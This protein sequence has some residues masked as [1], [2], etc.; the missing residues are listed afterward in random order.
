MWVGSLVLI[1]NLPKAEA[2]FNKK[3]SLK[4]S[5]ISARF[6]ISLGLIRQSRYQEARRLIA[7]NIR[8]LNPDL[9]PEDQF[10]IYQS[11]A[12][13]RFFCGRYRLAKKYAEKAYQAAVESEFTFGEMISKDLL[14]HSLIQT[15]EVHKG[16]NFFEETLKIAERVKNSWLSAAIRIS[17]LKFR[18]QFGLNPHRDLGD[19]E[20]A[21]K[22][23]KPQDTYSL[24][25]L[26]LEMIRQYLL[27]GQFSQAEKCLSQASDIIYKH[28]NRRQIALLNLRMSYMLFLQAQHTQALHVLRFSEQNI[29]QKVDLSLWT[30]M[31][32]LKYQILKTL[33]HLPEAEKTL[34]ALKNKSNLSQSAINRKILARISPRGQNLES[35]SGQDLI[36]DLLDKARTQDDSTPRLITE[37]GYYG[38]LHKYYQVPFGTQCLILDLVPGSV[39][40]LD[41]GNVTFKKKA[42]NSLLRKIIVLLKANAQ[43]KEALVEQIWGYQYDP[44]RHDT[45]VYSSIN[46]VRKLLSPY[47]DWIVLT[48]DG[49]RIRAD[50]KVIIKNTLKSSDKKTMAQSP[51]LGT[52]PTQLTKPARTQS[53]IFKDLNFRQLQIVDYL[54]KNTSISIFE[55][56][57]KLEI[58]K[59]TATRD[60]SQLHR[61]GILKRIGKGRA[62]RYLA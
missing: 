42:L 25:E 27:R 46:K 28:Q 56:S 37:S 52:H 36:C 55:L 34:G 48:E 7:Q 12:F 51:Q 54:N 44:L 6:F 60:L 24:A 29:D 5:P 33:G 62:T 19:L 17:L 41:K 22:A 23:L 39:V 20:D 31:T 9:N 47:S 61:L 38:L 57:Q 14:A 32:G 26:L 53:K 49:Y 16:L 4:N 13:Y 3:S 43:S 59:P 2:L 15:G 58:S 21:I 40:I 30:Q 18:A 8:S 45:L 11:I 35:T 10:F 1:G 50:I